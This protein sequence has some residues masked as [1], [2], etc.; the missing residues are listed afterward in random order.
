MRDLHY[1]LA[2]CAVKSI[3]SSVWLVIVFQ[4]VEKRIKWWYIWKNVID[5]QLPA[6]KSKVFQSPFTLCLW[7]SFFHSAGFLFHIFNNT[8]VRFCFQ[9]AAK[10]TVYGFGDF[11]CSQCPNLPIST[12]GRVFN[13]VSTK[14]KFEYYKGLVMKY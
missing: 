5:P 7:F 9:V 1:L 11:C 8:F 14:G 3:P 10:R 12:N 6:S 13:I 4:T 2:I